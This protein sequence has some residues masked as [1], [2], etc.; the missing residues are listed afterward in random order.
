LEPTLAEALGKLGYVEGQTARFD[1]RS[2]ENDIKRLPELAAALVHAK[3]D[4][5]VAVS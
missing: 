4:L 2:A 3:V 1:A 5:I